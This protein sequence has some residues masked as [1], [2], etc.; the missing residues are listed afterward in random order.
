MLE[1]LPSRAG[2]QPPYLDIGDGCVLPEL[3]VVEGRHINTAGNENAVRNLSNGLATEK[4]NRKKK[5]KSPRGRE[6]THRQEGTIQT[7]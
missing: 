4:A 6:G 7:A 2:I 1:N 3:L 5:D